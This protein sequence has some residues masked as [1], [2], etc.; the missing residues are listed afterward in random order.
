MLCFIYK[1]IRENVTNDDMVYIGSTTDPIHRMETHKG[2]YNNPNMPESYNCKL[3]KYIR[4]NGGINE[5]KMIIIAEFEIFN[6]KCKKRNNYEN[7]FI[8][9]YDAIN[10]LNSVRVGC[11]WKENWKELR[12][13]D[14]TWISRNSK[15]NKTHLEKNREKI[16]GKKRE[17]IPC[18][19]CGTLI[20][21]SSMA[22]HKRRFN[23][24][25]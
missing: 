7:K 17:K 10:K 18:D 24:F 5:W 12:K 16:N 23:C 21:Y 14:D 20:S 8:I 2:K 6:I 19:V 22:R 15:Y 9:A 25:L 3:Y 1:L 11:N 4:E 13:N